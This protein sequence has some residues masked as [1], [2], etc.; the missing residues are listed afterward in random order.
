[1]GGFIVYAIQ[2][3]KFSRGK[4]SENEKIW[5]RDNTIN[6]EIKLF[7]MAILLTYQ[8]NVR[9]LTKNIS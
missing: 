8:L 5:I 3:L 9:R 1:M 4:G 6:Y 7:K 2:L